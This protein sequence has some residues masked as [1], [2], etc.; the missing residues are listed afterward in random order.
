MPSSRFLSR[1]FFVSLFTLLLVVLPGSPGL[2]GLL[3]QGSAGANGGAIA[4]RN[5]ADLEQL[6]PIELQPQV[7][8]L[9]E[10]VKPAAK[11]AAKIPKKYDVSLIGQRKVDQ[12]V[13]FYSIDKEIAM[14]K[15]MAQELEAQSQ[16]LNDAV[17]SNY[18]EELGQRLARSSDIKEPL[19]IKVVDSDE[20]NAY[21]LPGGYFYVNTGLILAAQSEAELTAV[22]AHEIAHIAARH[23]TK[24]MT[25]VQIWNLASI[26][27]MFFGGPIGMAVQQVSALALPLSI[28]KFSRDAEREADLLGIEYQYAAGYDPNAFI[29]FFE[30]LKTGRKKP[31]A[32]AQ[33]FA[34][35]PMNQERIR[36]A[37]KTISTLLPPHDDYVVDTSQFHA[38]QQRLLGRLQIKTAPGATFGNGPVLR[39]DK[40]GTQSPKG[41]QP[42]DQ[43]P[44]DQ[45]S[46]RPTLKRR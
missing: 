20:V 16:L 7:D 5:P 31:N 23:A 41:Q 2:N 10:P 11:S 4:G 8:V 43:Q 35:H 27:M 14:G 24:N 1:V 19:I 37:E 26:P 29:D 18:V 46:D 15:E 32:V 12:G 44:D 28:N 21:A 38:M 6:L 45:Q 42:D 22:M 17:V 34:T 36:K 30:R 40:A 39:R 25:K 13:N 33:A 9:P 3:A